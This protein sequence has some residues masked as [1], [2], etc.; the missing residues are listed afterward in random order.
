MTIWWQ[1]ARCSLRVRRDDATTLRHGGVRRAQ[2]R[3][4]TRR[5]PRAHLE[6]TEDGVGMVRHRRPQTDR[7][8]WGNTM[9]HALIAAAASLPALISASTLPDT[10]SGRTGPAENAADVN[11]TTD[12]L[13][14][15]ERTD[16][17]GDLPS[18]TV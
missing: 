13:Q 2:R 1:D 14:R 15:R 8:R 6:R 9:K 10:S 17:W 12:T 11:I 16:W 18:T 7:A 4:R 5:A 3:A